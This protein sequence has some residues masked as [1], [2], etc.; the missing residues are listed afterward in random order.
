M[1]SPTEA[2]LRAAVE[3]FVVP[4][5]WQ[6]V[7]EA[8]ALRELSLS[9]DCLQV[10]LPNVAEVSQ[11]DDLYADK[12]RDAA[13]EDKTAVYQAVLG[14]FTGTDSLAEQMWEIVTDLGPEMWAVFSAIVD[15]VRFAADQ[16]PH[17]IFDLGPCVGYLDGLLK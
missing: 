16:S 11:R 15:G 17:T 10:A 3:S 1:A 13:G 5:S 7:A 4:H 8:R 6:S 14:R 12:K 9:G 2:E